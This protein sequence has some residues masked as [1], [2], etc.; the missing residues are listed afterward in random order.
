MQSVLAPKRRRFAFSK[1][2]VDDWQNLPHPPLTERLQCRLP[3]QSRQV[4]AAFFLQNLGFI[5][6]LLVHFGIGKV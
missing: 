4:E 2:V 1:P 5:A 3:R 6:G